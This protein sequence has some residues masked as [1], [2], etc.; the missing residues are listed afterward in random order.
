MIYTHVSKVTAGGQKPTKCAHWTGKLNAST[1]PCMGVFWLDYHLATPA[2]AARARSE[3]IYKDE[4]FT[5]HAPITVGCAFR[6]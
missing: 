2:F 4:W 6:L 1:I 5:D 3:A